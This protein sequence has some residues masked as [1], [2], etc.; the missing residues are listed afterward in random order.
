[1]KTFAIAVVD[2]S[3]VKPEQSELTLHFVKGETW[4]EALQKCTAIWWD[5]PIAQDY[6]DMKAYAFSTVFCLVEVKEIE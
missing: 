3:A 1:M 4:Q 6:D 2:L 5:I